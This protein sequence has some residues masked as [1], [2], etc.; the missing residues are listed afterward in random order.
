M[1]ARWRTGVLVLSL[2]LVAST[3]WGYTQLAGRRRAEA[4]LSTRYQQAFF[5]ALGSIENVEVLLAKALVSASPA[6]N[7]RYL[8][9]LWQQ[10]FAA[11]ASLNALP[12]RQ[13]TLMRTSRFLTQL[14]DFTYVLGR[15]VARGETVTAADWQT[16]EDLYRQVTALGSELTQIA[17][18]SA[19]GAM[20]W[21]EVRQ[22]TNFTLNPFSKRLGAPDQ[23][24]GFTRLDQQMQEF[25]TLVYDGPFSDHVTKREPRGLTGEAV[26]S[27]AARST[28][29]QFVPVPAAEREVWLAEQVAETDGGAPIAAWR[30]EV[31]RGDEIRPAYVL[32]VAKQGGSV[33]WMLATR[34]VARNAS[35]LSLAEAVAV[36]AEFLEARGFTGFEVTYPVV[37]DGRAVVPFVL[38]QDGTLLYPDQVKVT[39]ALDDGQVVGFDALQYYTNHYGRDLPE[40]RLSPEEARARV[41]ADLDIEGVRLALIPRPDRSEALTYEVRARL[42]E[43]LYHI[44]IDAVEGDE[45]QILRIVE[46]EEKGRL[47]L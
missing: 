41:R 43:D 35:A 20:P 8:T 24:D 27:F 39:V 38:V 26:D 6:E 14:G 46:S 29:L 11:Q 23:A 30:I 13:G 31:R 18:A 7:V 9:E 3:A 19:S 45:E 1:V 47:A 4:M 2:L 15:K 5:D 33:L 12:L 37:E 17:E 34:P 21:E 28:A 16:L 36:A 25:P 42:G 32:D 10:S 40:P 44:Y 22:R